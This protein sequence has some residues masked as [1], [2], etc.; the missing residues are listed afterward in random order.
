VSVAPVQGKT[1]QKPVYFVSQV[2]QDAETRYQMIE[3][4]ALALVHAS[5]RLQP[6]FQSHEIIVQ[7]DCPI[8]KVLRKPELAGRMIGWS[9]ELSEFGIKYEPRGPI[10][11]QCLVD[12]TSEL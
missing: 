12:F 1:D 4:V 11:S 2:F 6:Y 9:I 10:K 8:S 5:R 7:T 3:K